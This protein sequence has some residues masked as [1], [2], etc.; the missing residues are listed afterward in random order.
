MR[1]LLSLLL[2][3][4]VCSCAVNALKICSFNIQSF[5]ETK[6]AKGH[7]MAIIA[8]VTSR[9]DIM[10]VMEVKDST[11]SSLVSLVNEL[12]RGDRRKPYTYI[13]S[14][15][16][17]RKSYKEQYAFIYRHTTVSVL[18]RYQYM[19]EQIGDVDAFSREPF[20]VKFSSPTTDIKEFIL[21]PQHTTPEASVKELDELY[22]VYMDVKNRWKTENMIFLGDFNAGCTYVTRKKWSQIRIRMEEGFHWLIGDEIDT[23][24]NANTRC[25]YDR[26][27]VK[28]EPLYR[29]VVPGSAKPFNFQAAYGLSE[30]EA[31]EVSDHFP[32]EVEIK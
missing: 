13:I 28:G 25:A 11:G 16:L 4:A 24:V 32:I 18:D 15:R 29:A 9:C 8:K 6:A 19:D 21:I 26:I 2:L 10:L 20:V 17:G 14:D 31:L 27:V 30:T 5:G 23:T 12:N 3:L 7:V 1:S 22:D